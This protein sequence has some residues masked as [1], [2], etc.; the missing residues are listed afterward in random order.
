M[1]VS[2]IIARARRVAK[3]NTSNYVDADALDDLNVIKDE[4][5]AEIVSR[6]EED[7]NWEEWKTSSVSGQWEY[8]LP[9]LTSFGDG[10]KA[11]KTVAISYGTKTY[12]DGGLQ[13][14]K[15]KLVNPAS[16]E[17]DWDYYKNNQS[18][19]NPVYYVSDN[20]IFIAPIP[21]SAV[22]D[23]IKMTGI[24]KIA[25]YEL[26]TVEAD[27]GIPVDF[28]R[29]LVFGL[30]YE[31]ALDKGIPSNEVVEYFNTYEFNKAKALKALAM[32]S[33]WPVT[34]FYPQET[35]TASNDWK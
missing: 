14:V 8:T 13:Y 30:A 18:E 21:Q 34:M 20:S 32:R 22:T 23:G 25:D 24:R 11:L 1:N 29:V 10:T 3:Y 19:L 27:I 33:E 9:P 6:L 7:Y 4:F 17:L 16:M 5:W 15:A 12:D 35:E 26:W 28:H 31:M 2:Q